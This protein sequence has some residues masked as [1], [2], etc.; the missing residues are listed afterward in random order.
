MA[1]KQPGITYREIMEQ[2]STA[3][4][5]KSIYDF[6]P[7]RG[8][9][10]S[11]PPSGIV[12]SVLILPLKNQTLL[13]FQHTVIEV[14]N[15]DC[16]QIAQEALRNNVAV[17]AV[18]VS[19]NFPDCVMDARPE[20]LNSRIGV[21][22]AI[23]DVQ[24]VPNGAQIAICSSKQGQLLNV[25]T[26]TDMLRGEFEIHDIAKIKDVD[27]K[28]VAVTEFLDELY[29]TATGFLEESSRKSLY[30]KINTLPK[31]SE[32]QFHFKLQNSPVDDED[33]YHVM[34]IEDYEHRRMAFILELEKS[35]KILELRQEFHAKTM[36]EI[37]QRQKEE[38][39]RTQIRIM[40]N[41]MGDG[42]DEIAQ[43]LD[44]AEKKEWSE[45]TQKAFEKELRRLQRYAPNTPDYAIQYSY[46]DTF[47]ELPWQ[48]CDRPIFELADVEKTLDRDHYGL[49]KVK[50][51]IVEHMAVLKLR[52]DMKAPII[53]L[54]GPPGVGKT[55][56]GKSVADALGRKYVRVSLGG[57]HD[58]A[59]IRGHRRT[60]L[61]S[62]PG[63]II[64]ALQQCGTS[65]PVM[66]LDEIDK[67]GQDIKGDPSSALLEV[68]D[69]EQ[70]CKFHDNYID[71]DYD[72]S[73]VLFIATANDLSTISAP[74]LDRMEL[75]EIGGYVEDEKIQIASRYLVPK[76]LEL[77]GFERDDMTFTEEALH[78]IIEFHTRESGVRRLEKKIASV[79]RKQ[80][81]KK[82]S[83]KEYPHLIDAAI[84]KEALGAQEVFPDQYENNDI[85]GVVTGLAW[86]RAG[87]EI[88]FI[89][90][91]LA[92]GKEGKL[93]LTGNLGDV[94]K[95]SATI[96]LQ[97]LKAHADNY[98][99]N[100]DSMNGYNV[101]IHVPEGAVPKDGPSAGITMLTAL[102]SAYTHRKV[103]AKLAMTG[104]M[105]LRG[106]VLPVGGIKEK[107]LAAKRA[108]ITDVM[109]C[110]QNRKDI[111]EIKPEYISGMNFHYVDTASEVL[112][113]ALLPLE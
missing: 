17:V 6:V 54:Y 76:N 68:L 57:V 50:E 25:D 101:H 5:L 61:G 48:H 15:E 9:K 30:D 72:L 35:I 1:K 71:H 103:R 67:L 37:S 97:Y 77:H 105:T 56:L 80:A 96:A 87:G 84:V 90:A 94:M 32:V 49:E 10:R 85:P 64:T 26:H 39:M 60:Y 53:C 36:G 112:D 41:E 75:I 4:G 19:S 111:E 16:A 106:R 91:S 82:A 8:R 110:S 83:G 107:I 59:E 3:M 79:I 98:G 99:L 2:S 40:Q 78:E 20:M 86:T 7:M 45:E 93:T 33:I 13:P 113:F 27:A 12:E 21:I 62:M 58:E 31:D 66:V 74:L 34:T 29:G 47:L 88:L 24:C 46:L 100:N 92:P 14:D 63:R 43:L 95:E 23:K 102:A 109:L 11:T 51:R 22:A 65:D 69:P 18:H 44:R 52:N 73:N 108:G 38:F 89:E 28:S 81:C 55:S 104:E 70:N 42:D